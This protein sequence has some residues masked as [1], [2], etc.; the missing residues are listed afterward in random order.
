MKKLILAV[1]L[2]V[3]FAAPAL[4]QDFAQGYSQNR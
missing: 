3:A 4:A 1:A 2:V